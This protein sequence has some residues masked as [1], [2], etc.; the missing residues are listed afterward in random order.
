MTHPTFVAA[1]EDPVEFFRAVGVNQP[2]R[3]KVAYEPRDLQIKILKKLQSG[4]NC[5][6]SK[7]RQVGLTS[8]LLIY[9]FWKAL[10]RNN[11]HVLFIT[12]R[13]DAANHARQNIENNF[14][15]SKIKAIRDIRSFILTYTSTGVEFKNGSSVEFVSASSPH[16][17]HG[18][19]LD[20]IILDEF[21][22]YINQQNIVYSLLPMVASGGQIVLGSTPNDRSETDFFNRGFVAGGSFADNESLRIFYNQ[23]R[24]LNHTIQNIFPFNLN[25]AGFFNDEKDFFDLMYNNWLPDQFF[26]EGSEDLIFY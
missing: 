5:Y 4:K 11:T 14:I 12:L 25:E 15:K 24:Y 23:N 10:F 3:G 13:G 18:K 6:I 19:R 2:Q 20:V 21:D 17:A 7:P 16:F 9:A 26:I 8:T 1:Q 22:Y